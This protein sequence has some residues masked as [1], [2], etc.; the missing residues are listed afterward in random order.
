MR[1]RKEQSYNQLETSL[2]GEG[3]G[4]VLHRDIGVTGLGVTLGLIAVQEGE[5]RHAT[6]PPGPQCLR[7][8]RSPTLFGEPG[9]TNRK[10]LVHGQSEMVGLEGVAQ[11]RWWRSRRGRDKGSTVIAAYSKRNHVFWGIPQSSPHPTALINR[12]RLKLP[13]LGPFSN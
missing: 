10:R 4:G 3:K 1:S 8:G 2:H 6:P 12:Q 9:E 7:P 11:R 13:G 5:E